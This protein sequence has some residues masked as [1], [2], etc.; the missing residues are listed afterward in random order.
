MFTNYCD[1]QNEH[2]DVII[3][4]EINEAWNMHMCVDEYQI[5]SKGRG[6]LWIKANCTVKQCCFFSSAEFPLTMKEIP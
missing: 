1:S 5:M 6:Y 4:S 2:A 3:R